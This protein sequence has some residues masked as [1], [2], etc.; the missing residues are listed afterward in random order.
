MSVIVLSADALSRTAAIEIVYTN[1]KRIGL[2][3]RQMQFAERCFPGF[4]KTLFVN[5]ANFA[6]KSLYDSCGWGLYNAPIWLR[7]IFAPPEDG[8]IWECRLCGLAPAAAAA[9]DDLD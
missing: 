5:D 8:F 3:T 9:D 2:G 4:T 7:E 6:G 1:E